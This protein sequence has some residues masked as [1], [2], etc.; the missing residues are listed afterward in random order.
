MPTTVTPED[1]KSTPIS[2]PPH[3]DTASRTLP[4][5]TTPTSASTRTFKH[6]IQA[7][8][9]YM[10]IRS[11]SGIVV[12]KKHIN[13]S[14]SVPISPIPTNY[15]SALKDPNWHNAMREEFNVLMNQHTWSLVPRHA[16]VNVVTD[17]WIY[18]HKF[19]TDGT[20]ARYKVRW[21]VCDFTQQQG[22][23]YK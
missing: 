3:Q 21:V 9:D 16:G 7:P 1:A 14:T 2:C 15:R 17:K 10:H 20:L 19:N 8:T 4:T 23:D 12:P 18:R 13:L 22:V 11:K 5:H 6:P